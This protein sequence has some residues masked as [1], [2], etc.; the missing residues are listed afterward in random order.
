[1]NTKQFLQIYRALLQITVTFEE[2]K[3]GIQITLIQ[4]LFNIEKLHA[5][6]STFSIPCPSWSK[7]TL[8]WMSLWPF[9]PMS[10]RS[11]DR[12]QNR[13]FCQPM[14]YRP[15]AKSSN[16]LTLPQGFSLMHSS[17]QW[18]A[19]FHLKQSL[20]GKLSTS[21]AEILCMVSFAVC[22]FWGTCHDSA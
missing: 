20:S 14:T 11:T 3:K 9:P 21:L 6:S 2:I 12:R 7:E 19:D 1:M 8:D 17:T 22:C 5:F 4:V 10:W 16:A 15:R 13:V 18:W